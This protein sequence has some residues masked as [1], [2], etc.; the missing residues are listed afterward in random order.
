MQYFTQTIKSTICT[1]IIV[2]VLVC[3]LTLTQQTAQVTKPTFLNVIY[4]QK[5]DFVISSC[6]FT[7][8]VS[9]KMQVVTRSKYL[10]VAELNVRADGSV[11]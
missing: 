11:C 6:E 2:N 9:G 4:E 5:R 7:H 3:A 10:P 1:I 8:N